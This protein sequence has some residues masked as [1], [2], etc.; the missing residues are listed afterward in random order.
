MRDTEDKSLRR[1]FLSVGLTGAMVGFAGCT[2]SESSTSTEESD[3][4]SKPGRI[5]FLIIPSRTS[6]RKMDFE[7][8][9][10]DK[11][12]FD[13][14]NENAK[15]FISVYT[16]D[17]SR[18]SIFDNEYE[19]QGEYTVSTEVPENDEYTIFVYLRG[20]DAYV[21][22]RLVSQTDNGED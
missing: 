16:A 6:E 8:E 1:E 13:I 7:G 12:V 20:G 9:A 3:E 15:V 2:S 17:M 22:G 21:T 4:K 5:V 19:Q 18:S 14:K 11:L 10:G